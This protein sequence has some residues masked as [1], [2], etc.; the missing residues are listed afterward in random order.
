[1]LGRCDEE[2]YVCLVEVESQ[3]RDHGFNP[4]ER[5]FVNVFSLGQNLD[6]AI[7]NATNSLWE[8]GFRVV[9]VHETYSWID[10]L[11]RNSIS[12]DWHEQAG[13]ALRTGKCHYSAFF[14]WDNQG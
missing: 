5:S 10:V 12:E 8:I 4:G 11:R 7:A 1:M 13:H 3:G 2:L 9:R 14:S 6:G